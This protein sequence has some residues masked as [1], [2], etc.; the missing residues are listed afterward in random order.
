M[1][2]PSFPENSDYVELTKNN[3]TR[4][5]RELRDFFLMIHSRSD[6]LNLETRKYR[7]EHDLNVLN[8]MSVA[9]FYNRKK[10]YENRL[11]EQGNEY[12]YLVQLRELIQKTFS[13]HPNLS[14]TAERYCSALDEELISIQYHIEDLKDKVREYSAAPFEQIAL[15]QDELNKVK[16]ELQAELNSLSESEKSAMELMDDIVDKEIAPLIE[17]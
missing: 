6:L 5:K 3:C 15:I 10:F 16:S 11:K 2:M 17:S 13:F 12:T 9:A 4:L 14:S 8:Y 7:L 1:V